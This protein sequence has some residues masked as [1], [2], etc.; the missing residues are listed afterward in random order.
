[1]AFSNS[2]KVSHP[3]NAG[4]ELA[5][6]SRFERRAFEYSNPLPT[7]RTAISRH[8]EKIAMSF[9]SS[10]GSATGR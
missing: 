2:A 1:V 4:S 8:A 6:R 7:R 3:I 10:L 5:M 9:A